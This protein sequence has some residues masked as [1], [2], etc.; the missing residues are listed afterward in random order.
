[1]YFKCTTEI[2]VFVNECFI[3]ILGDNI[4]KPLYTH[5]KCPVLLLA[6]KFIAYYVAESNLFEWFSYRGAVHKYEMTT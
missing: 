6:W 4:N 2:L 1:M 5:I 3:P